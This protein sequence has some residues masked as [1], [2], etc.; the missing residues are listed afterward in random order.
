MNF[1]MDV[2]VRPEFAV[3]RIQGAEGQAAGQDDHRARMWSP[4][5]RVPG[6]LR[7]DRSQARGGGRD[8]RLPHGRPHVPEARRRRAERGQGNPV[9]A[10][11]GAAVPGRPRPG[12]RRGARG[13][14]AGRNARGRGQARLRPRPI[15]SFRGKTIQVEVPGQRPQAAAPARGQSG[16]PRLDRLRQPGRAAR[17]RPRRCWSGGS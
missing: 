16:V 2:E 4:A 15:P 10:P 7:P 8:R 17:R 9:P 6:T 5:R 14:Q 1:E 11:A 12:H 13:R 3:C